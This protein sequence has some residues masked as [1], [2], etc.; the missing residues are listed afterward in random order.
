MRKEMRR[1]NEIGSHVFVVLFTLPKDYQANE[2]RLNSNFV[3]HHRHKLPG[4][5][6]GIEKKILGDT[7]TRESKTSD[8]LTSSEPSSSSKRIIIGGVSGFPRT[9]NTSFI[10]ALFQFVQKSLLVEEETPYLYKHDFCV[11][12]PDSAPPTSVSKKEF[13]FID[14]R[15]YYFSVDHKSDVDLLRYYIR[16]I[17]AHSKF[18]KRPED[19]EQ[20]QDQYDP[21]TGITHLI[22]P[23]SARDIYKGVSWLKSWITTGTIMKDRLYNF[24]RLYNVAKH[25]LAE[26]RYDCEELEAADKIVVLVTHMDMIPPWNRADAEKQIRAAFGAFNVPENLIAFGAKECEWDEKTLLEHEAQLNKFL[27]SLGE[28]E[29]Y[30][31]STKS[32]VMHVPSDRC[33]RPDCQHL[34][35]E[36]AKQNYMRLLQHFLNS[37]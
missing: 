32:V 19:V 18:S 30:Y 17:R 13:C 35:T 1:E 21:R 27:Q 15:G 28:N 31:E 2:L 14:T 23:I 4:K 8:L 12:L 33:I 29:N 37:A 10:G 11:E 36:E 16:G 24:V 9:G 7:I 3:L 34:F 6:E 25:L 5:I 20:L 22:L 26:I